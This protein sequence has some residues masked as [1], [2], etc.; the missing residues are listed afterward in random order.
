MFTEKAV[1]MDMADFTKTRDTSRKLC[2]QNPNQFHDVA[3]L[4]YD[5]MK[6]YLEFC[7][8]YRNIDMS[9]YTDKEMKSLFH[10]YTERAAEIR[11]FLPF[12]TY[13]DGIILTLLQDELAKHP[14]AELH[15]EW[16]QTKKD[17]PFVAEHKSM[18]RIG[19]EIQ[20]AGLSDIN[21]LPLH[22]ENM[23]DT[24][25]HTYEWLFQL[26]LTGHP[27]T[28]KYTTEV[29]TE[30]IKTDCADRLSQMEKDYK[31]RNESIE[32]IKDISHEMRR[33][34][35]ICEEY[36]YLRTYRTDAINEGDFYMRSLLNE[37]SSRL[38]LSY[39]DMNCLT[40]DEIIDL[41]DNK[42][43]TK[44]LAYTIQARKEYYVMFLVNDED[45]HLL[46]GKKFMPIETQSSDNAS[47]LT[48]KVA[49]R[50]RVI[51]KVKI[52]WDERDVKK[53]NKD[54][55]IVAPMTTPDMMVGILKCRGIITDEGGIASHAAQI[56][57]E[58]KIPCIMGT[59]NATKLLQDG[60]KIEIIADGASGSVK[61]L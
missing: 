29:L 40:A 47:A 59:G 14:G 39:D 10:E 12:V 25:I 11:S 31:H 53:V 20:K 3:K 19:A 49:Q 27:M 21:A 18:L 37:I 7:K 30:L 45:I 56:S 8:K 6:R 5:C 9:T 43:K 15:N 4:S 54:D 2:E 41:L 17:L 51:G 13:H 48:G 36:A 22:I 52:V 38:N 50:G 24:H 1:Y 28:R 57:R 34:L 44:D 42:K 46:G 33:L 55:I 35:N 58:F 32:K 61:V 26:H 16:I 60:D 23:I